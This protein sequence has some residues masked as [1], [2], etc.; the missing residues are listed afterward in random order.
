MTKVIAFPTERQRMIAGLE[1]HVDEALETAGIPDFALDSCRK[2]FVDHA[3]SLFDDPELFPNPGVIQIPAPLTER[4]TEAIK[5]YGQLE[6]RRKIR[7]VYL[8]ALQY[9]L[10]HLNEQLPEGK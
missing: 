5:A 1:R 8:A 7:I 10:R 9:M 4:Q 2:A 3:L 6:Q